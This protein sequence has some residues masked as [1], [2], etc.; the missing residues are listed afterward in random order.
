MFILHVYLHARILSVAPRGNIGKCLIEKEM[1]SS[2]PFFI[3]A[4]KQ[5]LHTEYSCCMIW[6][7]QTGWCPVLIWQGKEH[8]CWRGT[9]L[10]WSLILKSQLFESS[11]GHTMAFPSIRACFA[12]RL[13]TPGL[14]L[15]A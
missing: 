8:S 2:I 4:A 3:S 15:R 5:H 14:G 10:K 9:V 11:E 6:P 7:V 1:C 12:L 13:R